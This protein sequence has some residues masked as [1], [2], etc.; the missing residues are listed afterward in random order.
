[1]KNAAFAT[2]I[3]YVTATQQWGIQLSPA[4]GKPVRQC[5]LCVLE[6][7]LKQAAFKKID[8]AQNFGFA[9]VPYL[10][11]PDLATCFRR[12]I[13]SAGDK[14]ITEYQSRREYVHYT[15]MRDRKSDMH[16]FQPVE[17][18]AFY[19]QFVLMWTAWNHQVRCYISNHGGSF[20]LN[21]DQLI[22]F[23]PS[24]LWYRHCRQTCVLTISGTARHWGKKDTVTRKK[25]VYI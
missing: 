22:T 13:I 7:K 18:R 25:R 24:K 12:N 19:T 8:L 16:I 21:S 14:T 23:T 5:P 10:W 9:D 6:I 1:M 11:Y 17:E 2:K 4:F 3:G 15:Q 20:P